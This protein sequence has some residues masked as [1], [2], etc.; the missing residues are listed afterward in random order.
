LL[1]KLVPDG[2]RA[3][4]YNAW[5]LEKKEPRAYREDLSVLLGL[6]ALRRIGPPA[7]AQIPLADAVKAHELMER[8]G[9]V[10]KIVLTV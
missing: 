6:L 10:G 5:S 4:F 7:V 9:P 2:K 8:G 1:P 3:L